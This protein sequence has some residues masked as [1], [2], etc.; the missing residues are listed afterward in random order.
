MRHLRASLLL[1]VAVAA[2]LA[3]VGGAG[4]ATIPITSEPAF[5]HQI[6]ISPQA[7]EYLIND[8]SCVVNFI[9]GNGGTWVSAMIQSSNDGGVTWSDYDAFP[10]SSSGGGI[11]IGV[12]P[13]FGLGDWRFRAHGKNSSGG[14]VYSD[15]FPYNVNIQSCPDTTPPNIY[16]GPTVDP[17]PVSFGANATLTFW[18]SDANT[19][20]NGE[21]WADTDPGVGNG[22]A[23]QSPYGSFSVQLSG[24]AVGTHTIGVRAKDPSGNWSP[25]ATT[26]LTVLASGSTTQTVSGG[27]TI[28][29]DPLNIG[30]TADVPVQ[31]QLSLPVDA[32]TMTISINA[33]PTSGTSPTGYDFFG[34]Q[35][36]IDNGGITTSATDP[37]VLTFTVDSSLLGGI[38]ASDVQVF[39][40]GVALPLCTDSTAAIPDACVASTPTANTDGDAVVTIRTTHFSTWNLGRLKYGFAGFLQPVDNLPTVNTTNAGNAI[41]VKFSL[42]GNKGLNI[43][44]SGYPVQS[45]YSCQTGATTDTI[46][47]TVAAGASGLSYDSTSNTYTYVWKSD[48][49]W[50]GTCRELTLS[51]RDGS[52]Q[53]A[54]FQF[55]K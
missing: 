30:A 45:A 41:P 20:P 22:I 31:T 29:T 42:G 40:D 16:S 5:C 54:H 18:A 35:V 34:N 38:A 48:K 2:A 6:A 52:T 50:A 36:A 25:T 27:G 11:G 10:Y 21:Y 7:G 1:L 33:Q 28:T 43:F 4:A 8:D 14:D 12:C 32:G 26:S 23:I 53:R 46:E 19:A 13:A 24:L 15:P 49:A 51:F 37:Y 44:R 17:N 9:I 55:S 47:Q 39:R 3:F